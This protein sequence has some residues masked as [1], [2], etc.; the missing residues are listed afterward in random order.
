[1]CSRS[2]APPPPAE[3]VAQ[4][5]TPSRWSARASTQ[6][7]P[8]LCPGPVATST[9]WV[10][11]AAKRGANAASTLRPARLGTALD[12]IAGR[13]ARA[14]VGPLARLD[15]RAKDAATPASLLDALAATADIDPART[16]ELCERALDEQIAMLLRAIALGRKT[17][18]DPADLDIH[19]GEA[20]PVTEPSADDRT[21][22]L[23]L[24]EVERRHVR[25]ILE[26]TGWN[27]THAART[28]DISPTTL[29]KKI[30]DYGLDG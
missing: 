25:A 19:L 22:A 3:A 9:P 24:R 23:S 30:A 18:L 7:S 16:D 29:R 14:P 28:L 15:A 10:S 27:I 26:Q 11:R 1:M 6:P 20:P 4:T 2:S 13:A 17:T 12:E 5:G 8:P 21:T